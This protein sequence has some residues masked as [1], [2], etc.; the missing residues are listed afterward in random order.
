MNPNAFIEKI[1]AGRWIAG[2]SIDDAIEKSKMF[3]QHGISTLIN[4]LG[5]NVTEKKE[6]NNSIETYIRLINQIKKEKV[7]ASISIK[8]TQIGLLV[9]YKFFLSNYLKLAKLAKMNKINLWL[10]MEEP[11]YVDSTIKA[12]KS[13]I[14]YGNT[15]ICIQSYLKRSE[16]D[17]KELVKYNCKIRLV[18]GAYTIKTG[19]SF[20]SRRSVNHNFMKL[21]KTLFEKSDNFVIATHDTRI[22]EEA[23]KLN[24]IC[25]K[26]VTF[27]MLNGIR[28]RYAKYLVE[29]K[30]KVMIYV[31]FGKDWMG[32]S[33]RRL[34]EEG[35]LSL[36]LR[37]LFERQTL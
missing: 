25:K 35:H 27:A 33:L 3:N 2:Y 18:K 17:V 9:G 20:K 12:Y 6:V 26:N 10:D 7:S 31:P 22:V 28:N 11:E 16:K 23:I 37:S 15:G 34:T 29:N 5:E 19:E 8:P 14:K 30:Q 32:Y 36:I 21:M 24:K 1:F 13:S 4:F